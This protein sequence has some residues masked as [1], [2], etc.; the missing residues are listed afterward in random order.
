[1]SVF[2]PVDRSLPQP[3]GMEK[4]AKPLLQQ[5]RAAVPEPRLG[6]SLVAEL[7]SLLAEPLDPAAHGVALFAT[8]GRK[9]RLDL[10]GE[11]APAAHV[12]DMPVLVPLVPFTEP[13][14]ELFVLVL[15]RHDVRLYTLDR[16]RLDEV[17]VEGLPRSIEDDLWYEQHEPSMNRHGGPRD[18]GVAG[19][20]GGGTSERDLRKAAFDR[21]AHHVAKALRPVL[22]AHRHPLVVAALPHDAAAFRAACDHE[23]LVVM[24]EGTGLDAAHLRAAALAA[25]APLLEAPT[26]AALERFASKGGTGLTETD[27][28]AI[29]EM[30]AAGRVETLLVAADGTDPVVVAPTLTAA[31]RT[32]AAVLPVTMDRLQGL[33]VGALLRY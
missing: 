14:V 2:V 31:L 22:A 11:V 13:A 3:A 6:E 27:P 12:A 15:G 23:P 16:T 1:M 20:V 17:Q 25:A 5:V 19:V 28:A 10:A 29:A 33:P 7:E 24:G 26:V 18:A 32:G 8:T 21:F 4:A 9:M 30:A